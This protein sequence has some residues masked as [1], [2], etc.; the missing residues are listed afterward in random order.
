MK[1]IFIYHAS[2]RFNTEYK[3]LVLDNFKFNT[4]VDSYYCSVS[5]KRILTF[6]VYFL[7]QKLKIFLSRFY[8]MGEGGGEQMN[9]PLMSGGVPP[10]L[11]SQPTTYIETTHCHRGLHL[12]MR[13]H[14][15]RTERNNKIILLWKPLFMLSHV[16]VKCCFLAF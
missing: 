14:E 9:I 7:Q 11:Y 15:R 12:H 6:D 13:S 8:P 16:T 3:G 10:P 4:F 1:E 2:P 5:K